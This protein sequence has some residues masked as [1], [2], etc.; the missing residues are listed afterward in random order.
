MRIQV[1]ESDIVKN[2]IL[3]QGISINTNLHVDLTRILFFGIFFGGLIFWK[4][5][6]LENINIIEFI[7]GDKVIDILGLMNRL[8]HLIIFSSRW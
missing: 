2:C 1:S 8:Q 4:I 5:I 6:L 7:F 3:N